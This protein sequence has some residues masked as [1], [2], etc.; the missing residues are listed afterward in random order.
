MMIK[1]GITRLCTQQPKL[2]PSQKNGLFMLAGL[3]NM[4]ES[5]A[6]L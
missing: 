2:K 1:Q 4:L 6:R 3:N 5:A